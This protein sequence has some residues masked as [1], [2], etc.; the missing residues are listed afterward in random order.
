M[1]IVAGFGV[2][3]VWSQC[4]S[5]IVVPDTNLSCAPGIFQ[6]KALNVP[7]GSLIQWN[8]G[9]GFSA[10]TDSFKLIVPD[11]DTIDLL[12]K[13]VLP[14]GAVCNR[15]FPKIVKVIPKPDPLFSISKNKIC[16]V[17]DS[18]TLTDN[19]K[20]SV[21]RTYLID[22]SLYGTNKTSFK[23]TF[24]SDGK[25]NIVMMAEDKYGCRSVKTFVDVAEVYAA[26]SIDINTFGKDLCIGESAAV[27]LNT[28]LKATEIISAVW[29]MPGANPASST[30]QTPSTFTYS[31]AGSYDVSVDVTSNKQ[32]TYTVTKKNA[33][34]IHAPTPIKLTLSDSVLCVPENVVFKVEDPKVAGI[35]KW[36]V[37]GPTEYDSINYFTRSFYFTQPGT[38][39]AEV[40]FEDNFCTYTIHKTGAIKAEK[41]A[42]DFKAESYYDCEI[43]FTAKF[44]NKTTSTSTGKITYE[45]YVLDTMGNILDSANTKDFQ[46]KVED[47]GY[48]DVQLIATHENGCVDVSNH[49]KLIRADSIRIVYFPQPKYVCLNQDVVLLNQS[50]NSSYRT[51]DVFRW[52]LYQHGSSTPI[53]SS[54]QLQPVFN[55]KYTGSYDVKVK[56]ENALGC[57][58]ED[59]QEEVFEVVVPKADFISSQDTICS[60][61]EFKLRPKNYPPSGQYRH[62]WK[63]VNGNDTTYVQYTEEP[64]ITLDK[65]GKYEV[66]YDIS[67][68][69]YCKDTA[70]KKNAFVIS[71]IESDFNTNGLRAC[72]NLGFDGIANVQN[73]VYGNSSGKIKYHWFS[74]T[75]GAAI[76]HDTTDHA[77]FNFASKGRYAIGLLAIN[78]NHCSDSSELKIIDVGMNPIIEL[79]DSSVCAGAEIKWKNTTDTFTNRWFSGIS[80]NT[81]NYSI[82][83]PFADSGTLKVFK[84]GDYI[85]HFIASRDSIC[86]D[87][88]SIPISIIAP[89]ADFHT[90]DSNFYCAPSYVRFR[91]DSE[92]ADTL[93]WDFGDGKKL[94]TTDYRVTTLY[95]ENTGSLKPF[96]VTLIAKNHSGCTDTIVKKD[97]IKIDGPAID[98]HLENFTGC[99][100]LKVKF[101]GQTQNVYKMYIDHGDGTDFGFELGSEHAYHNTYRIIEQPYNP[102]VLVVDKNGCTS[103]LKADSTVRVKPGPIARIGILDSFGC[104]PLTI[105]YLYLGQDGKTWNWDFD[106]NGTHDGN[107]AAGKHIYNIPGHYNMTLTNTNTWN[108]SDTAIREIYAV[109]PPDVDIGI[110]SVLCVGQDFSAT[111]LTQF[112]LPFKSREWEITTSSGSSK[113]T[114]SIITLPATG[115]GKSMQ[116]KLTV[117]D[118]LGCTAEKKLVKTIR[119]SANSEAPIIHVVSVADT[120][121][122]RMD[123][124]SPALP[125]QKTFILRD[126]SGNWDYLDTISPKEIVN[127]DST[128]K[129]RNQR[130]CYSLQHIDSC[131]YSSAQ[132]EKHC[133]ILLNIST[134]I[135]GKIDLNWTAYEGWTSVSKYQV[136]RNKNGVWNILDEVPGTQL[137][138]SD[139]DVC[140]DT[141][142]YRIEAI[143]PT[144]NY[145]SVSNPECAS[146]RESQNLSVTDVKVV[147]VAENEFVKIELNTNNDDDHFILIRENGS[148]SQ[149][150]ELTERTFEDHSVN[151]QNTSYFYRALGI[152][153]CGVQGKTGSPGNSILLTLDQNTGDSFTLR[154][155]PYEGWPGGVQRYQVYR[156]NRD[157]RENV[158]TVN[159]STLETKGS[160]TSN[161]SSAYCFV[162]EAEN[163]DT[164]VSTSN[165]VCLTGNPYVYIP[166]A[167]RPTSVNGN[168]IFRPSVLFIEAPGQSEKGLYEFVIADRWGGILFTSNNPSMG[169]DG[170]VDGVDV[171]EGSYFYTLRVRG[172]D[173][174]AKS[175]SGMVTLL[176]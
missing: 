110:S 12:L 124:A 116:I 20:G 143:D 156:L 57:K 134:A 32:C 99:E 176:R 101:V 174:F 51:N 77:T 105:D 62:N 149:E 5:I 27:S 114:D 126:N 138:Y 145:R 74:E 39:D 150:F 47:W 92:N 136:F 106:G 68:F 48:Y 170:K 131:G 8:T 117:T 58:Q 120:N 98:Y 140:P 121:V 79:E 54:Y 49:D 25:K 163:S 107:N 147:T 88:T 75:S 164:L 127:H 123:F 9:N 61:V 59:F 65:P 84:N 3:V 87:T 86:F 112:D 94:T 1:V 173:G 2:D 14:G 129:T 83:N 34:D 175:F 16:D 46:Y 111:D 151:V 90:L 17:A 109:A 43:P 50:Q 135:P 52:W 155:T 7:K 97:F 139:P 22:G 71:G 159:G 23:A 137:N 93:F 36:N 169:W 81:S 67:I 132:A 102:L 40:S 21:F 70:V 42:A 29:K 153:T 24:N 35:L 85:F 26:P 37:K 152:N 73:H 122:V 119:D 53:D 80:P 144:G 45:W 118:T 167:F 113:S 142:C 103:V 171:Q 128:T 11:P 30:K 44:T 56:A 154:W 146:I 148:L 96:T 64:E 100:P 66:I 31:K 108:C 13:I 172:S 15:S 115:S 158:K 162:V 76:D 104:A 89:V 82:S 161:G 63:L 10:G 91:S 38:F 41:L 19:T 55:A 133:T 160:L 95:T 130:Y 6:L 60:G 28:S 168:N 157:V 141:Y 166:N 78:S 165:E 4:N 125:Y 69:G 18:F 72:R 33:F